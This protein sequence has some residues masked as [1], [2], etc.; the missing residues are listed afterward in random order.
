MWQQMNGMGTIRSAP[1]IECFY[2]V[3][4]EHWKL[5]FSEPSIDDLKSAQEGTSSHVTSIPAIC[6]KSLCSALFLVTIHLTHTY[7]AAE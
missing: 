6:K 5:E 1:S 7:L 3:R 4:V 2:H